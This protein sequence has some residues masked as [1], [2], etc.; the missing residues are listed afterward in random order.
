MRDAL[1][2]RRS[3]R[4]AVIPSERSESRDLHLKRSH[5]RS[6]D[7]QVQSQHRMIAY[8]VRL[9]VLTG[10]AF[11]LIS[12]AASA[13][14]RGADEHWVATWGTALTLY[15]TPP[16]AAPPAPVPS[17]PPAA[18]TP[19]SGPARRFGIPTPLDGLRDQ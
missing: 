12:N 9:A 19:S 7:D 2:W 6:D 15:Q 8:R 10:F 18:S 13:Q 16:P 4:E 1:E 11:V 5:A 17:T 14:Q 3:L